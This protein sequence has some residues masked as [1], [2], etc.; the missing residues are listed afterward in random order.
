MKKTKIMLWLCV[1][2]GAAVQGLAGNLYVYGKDG[3]LR[4]FALSD[5]QRLTFSAN[6]MV[7]NPKN[8][9]ITS[10]PF[11][12]MAFFG[13][14]EIVQTPTGV[15]TSEVEVNVSVYPNPAADELTVNSETTITEVCLYDA[16]GRQLLQ[17]SV[18]SPQAKINMSAYPEG[19]YLLH[20]TTLQGLS[21]KKI[22]KN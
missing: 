4:S 8:G 15:A 13:L 2:C 11:S 3:A 19:W 22:V 12:G 17:T 5:V 18:Q 7:V 9:S 16:M 20:I 10:F 6:S 21:V 1:F 14:K